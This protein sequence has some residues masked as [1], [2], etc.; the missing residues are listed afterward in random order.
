MYL[1]QMS[2]QQTQEQ[3]NHLNDPIALAAL[4]QHSQ[5]QHQQQPLYNGTSPSDLT[6]GSIEPPLHQH[7]PSTNGFLNVNGSGPGHHATA[8]T[9]SLNVPRAQHSR[10]VSLPSFSQEPF[11]PVSQPGH[12]R[13][14]WHF[15]L[16]MRESEMLA[17]P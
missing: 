1:N 5:P 13:S 9:S 10:A 12:G 17:I 15:Q 11:G 16:A 3:E 2:A 8:S 7:K 4:Q 6:N 14:A